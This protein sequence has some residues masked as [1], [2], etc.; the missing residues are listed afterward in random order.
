MY[1]WV[2]LNMYLDMVAHV[3][4]ICATCI[5]YNENQRVCQYFG[6][7][8][9]PDDVCGLVNRWYLGVKNE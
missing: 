3:P 9:F 2:M 4:K 6:V 5:W 8:K 1:G 7:E